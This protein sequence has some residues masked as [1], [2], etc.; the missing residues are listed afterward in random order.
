M[1][2]FVRYI[3]FRD[4]RLLIGLGVREELDELSSIRGV[5]EKRRGGLGGV[6]DGELVMYERERGRVGDEEDIVGN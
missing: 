5:L 4:W 2:V 1:N 6:E 3:G